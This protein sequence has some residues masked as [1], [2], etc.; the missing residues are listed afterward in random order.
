MNICILLCTGE[1]LMTSH[2]ARQQRIK[3]VPFQNPEPKCKDLSLIDYSFKASLF[4]TSLQNLH[5]P[6]LLEGKCKM[7]RKSTPG[8]VWYDWLPPIST[9]LWELK[10]Q[11]LIWN[12]L[13][14]VTSKSKARVDCLFPEPAK[15]SIIPEAPCW[16][17]SLNLF[18]FLTYIS[19]YCLFFLDISFDHFFLVWL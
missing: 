15:S 17:S 9:D 7:Y 4:L 11:V 16:Y 14:S 12:L 6:E 10:F 1:I 5:H 19:L 3:R 13:L 2:N 8:S 18:S